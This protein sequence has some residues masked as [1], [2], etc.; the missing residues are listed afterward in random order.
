MNKI[1]SRDMTKPTK[2]E[3][4]QRRLRSAWESAQ[5]DQSLRCP[6]KESLG[7]ELHIESDQTGR[8]PRLIWVFAGRTATLLL[9]SCRGS[10]VQF[11]SVYV[12]TYRESLAVTNHS[13]NFCLFYIMSL[14]TVRVDSPLYSPSLTTISPAKTVAFISSAGES[15]I[16]LLGGQTFSQKSESP[17]VIHV[18]WMSIV[19][20]ILWL[21]FMF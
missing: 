1:L 11:Q 18:F 5:S 16:V 8:M 6:H 14:I 12:L 7:P 20:M 10:V 2:W 19:S 9:L 17:V 3:C 13:R 4:A 21:S 15:Y